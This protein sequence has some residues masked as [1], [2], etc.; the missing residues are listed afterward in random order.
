MNGILYVSCGTPGSGKSTFLKEMKGDNEVVISRDDIRFSILKPGQEYFSQDK[1]VYDK[2]LY[3]ITKYINNGVNVY[4][5]ATHLNEKSRYKLLYGLKNRGC[6]PLEIN[7][8][9]FNIPLSVCKERNLKRLGTKA[10][11]PEKDLEE[12]Y[13]HFTFPH[14]YEGFNNVYSVDEDGY[15]EIV[16][17][18]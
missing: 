7:A 16:E 5:D 2:F 13:S 4:A 9:Y 6:K 11:T 15:V 8:I 17:E 10:F 12:M 1:E 18:E 14:R 3:T